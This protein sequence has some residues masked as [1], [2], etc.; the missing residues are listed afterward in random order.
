[1][2]LWTAIVAPIPDILARQPMCAWFMIGENIVDTH[3]TPQQMR[4]L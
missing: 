4:A 3:H 1:M 2:E